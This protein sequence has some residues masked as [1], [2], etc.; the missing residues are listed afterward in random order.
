MSVD[1]DLLLSDHLST[2]PSKRR[3]LASVAVTPPKYSDLL[4]AFGA[5]RVPSSVSKMSKESAGVRQLRAETKQG[6]SYAESDDSGEPSP[7]GSSGGS[8]FGEAAATGGTRTSIDLTGTD[9]EEEHDEAES[10]DDV[11]EGHSFLPTKN[12]SAADLDLVAPAR[13]MSTREIPQ[14]ASKKRVSYV[15]AQKPKKKKS[16]KRQKPVKL[17]SD[18][19]GKAKDTKQKVHVETERNKVRNNIQEQIKPKRNAFLYAHKE[20]F[21]PLLPETSYID[22]LQRMYDM[23][24]DEPTIAQYRSITKQPKGITATMKAYQLEGLS[25][26][27]W[28]HK[29]GMSSILGD[30]MGLGKTLQTL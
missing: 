25:F 15:T 2:P 16:S 21:Q 1:T 4:A 3:K 6:F 8:A 7:N 14:R 22:K 30:E 18:L 20:Y 17:T 19:F 26:L 10:D 9:S 29:N 11:I 28:M 12:I 13:S 27:T 5:R 23:D 24:N